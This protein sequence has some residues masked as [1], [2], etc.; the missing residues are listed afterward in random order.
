MKVDFSLHGEPRSELFKNLLNIIVEKPMDSVSISVNLVSRYLDCFY[1][2]P[3]LLI[4]R[5]I[6][7]KKKYVKY[8]PLLPSKEKALNLS[9]VNLKIAWFFFLKIE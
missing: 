8:I 4:L 2:I 5:V 6:F 3:E 7:F 1:L 9:L